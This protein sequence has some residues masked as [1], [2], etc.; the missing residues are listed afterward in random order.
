MPLELRKSRRWGRYPIASLM[1]SLPWF[2]TDH[3]YWM[4]V[5]RTQTPHSS[6]EDIKQGVSLRANSPQQCLHPASQCP[7]EGWA[8]TPRPQPLGGSPKVPTVRLSWGAL[9]LLSARWETGSFSQPPS[10]TGAQDCV[11]SMSPSLWDSVLCLAYN[12][13]NSY[14]LDY[15]WQ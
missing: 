6:A 11:T 3:P 9:H 8:R 14:S 7:G 2:R 10:A 15:K 5:T 12:R 1:S 13:R 4:S